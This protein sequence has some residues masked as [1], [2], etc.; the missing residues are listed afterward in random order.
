MKIIIY[1]WQLPQ[2][3]LAWIL[4]LLLG[5]STSRNESLSVLTHSYDKGPY[6]LCLGDHI[7]IRRSRFRMQHITDRILAHEHGHAIQSHMLGPFYLLIVGIPSVAQNLLGELLRKFG[8]EEY[9]MNYYNRFPEKWAD[10]LGG[11]DR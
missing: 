8:Y 7:F 3:I 4:V 1:I 2:H 5:A 10:K 9:R 6:A 11:V